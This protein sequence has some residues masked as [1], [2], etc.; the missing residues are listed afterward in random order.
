MASIWLC[1]VAVTMQLYIHD[2]EAV[3]MGFI[4]SSMGLRILQSINH[5]RQMLEIPV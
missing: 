5:L 2:D 4:S 1:S 3:I